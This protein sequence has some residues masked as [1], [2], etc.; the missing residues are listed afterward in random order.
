MVRNKSTK[1]NDRVEKCLFVYKY[2]MKS[3]Y[4]LN[5]VLI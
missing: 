4:S 2:K 1:L 5:G 3:F